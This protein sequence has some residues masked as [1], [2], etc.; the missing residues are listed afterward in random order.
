MKEVGAFLLILVG[1]I[2]AI[3]FTPASDVAFSDSEKW[4]SL[5][6]LEHESPLAS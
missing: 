3:S 4:D 5:I 6:P 2:Y 1:S